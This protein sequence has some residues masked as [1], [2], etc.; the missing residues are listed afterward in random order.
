MFA[1]TLLCQILLAT[2]AFAIPTSKE[3]L[4][5]RVAR[6]SS[7]LTHQGRPNQVVARPAAEA[8]S[9]STHAEFSSNWSGAVLVAGSNTFKSVTGTFTVPTPKEPSGSSGTHSASAWVGIDGD[10]CGSAILQTGVDFTVSG[11]STSFDAWFEW[12]PDFATDFTGFSVRSGDSITATVT[13]TSLTGGTATLVNHRSGQTVSHTFSGQP[14]L[15]QENAEWI[16]EDFEEGS[17]LV[18]LANWGTVTFTGASAGLSSGSEGP[19]GA[20][21]INME[22]NSR[23]LTS[24]SASGSTVTVEYTGS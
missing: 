3:R 16:V 18:P 9:N 20:T 8:G 2:A 22:Q 4:A 10:T 12:F 24:V 7:G 1:A 19:S 6:R 23:V 21:I 15:C 14:A 5:Q 13:A 11:S 17:S